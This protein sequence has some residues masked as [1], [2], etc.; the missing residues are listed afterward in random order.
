MLGS[1]SRGNPEEAEQS[2][3]V[4]NAQAS[5]MA[6]G[7]L[8]G[9]AKRLVGGGA[10][11]VGHKGRQSPVLAEGVIFVRGRADRH[12]RGEEILP[13]PGIGAVGIDANG[14]IVHHGQCRGHAGELGIEEP[15]HPLV[16][17]H[18][19]TVRGGEARH[20]RRLRMA[21]RGRPVAPPLAI[22]FGEGTKNGKLVE[23]VPLGLAVLL[24]GRVAAKTLPELLQR[25]DLQPEDGI[26]IDHALLI[27][28]AT[29]G[30]EA[31]QVGA[32]CGSPRDLFNAQ[33]QQVA[34]AP[35]A[36]KIGAGL[37]REDREGGLQR[38]DQEQ[39][40]LQRRRRP[41]GQAAE[42]SQVPDAPTPVRPQGVELHGPAPLACAAW[43]TTLPRAHNQLDGCP[44]IER[45]ERMIAQGEIRRECRF[46]LEH[47]AILQRQLGGT[48]ER[49]HL[50]R[51]D[52][53]HRRCRGSALR[54]W[55][56]AHGGQE[57]QACCWRGLMPYAQGVLVAIVNAPYVCAHRVTSYA[58]ARA[59]IFITSIP[60][61]TVGLAVV[62]PVLLPRVGGS[63]AGGCAPSRDGC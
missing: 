47:G 13:D 21:V 6:E 20:G 50:V 12:V 44:A 58:S 14:Q 4:V 18:A 32:E 3:H 11:L 42:V 7:G 27:E 22:V 17:P 26:A 40:G 61:A 60:T 45:A 41:G 19:L 29:G 57:R 8:N 30:G 39:V 52:H 38:I 16:K 63:P 48:P 2:H 56:D 43:L 10:E 5:R 53:L 25:G 15:L 36:G 46:D 23:R 33:V 31:L 55:I 59:Y 35:A 51:P 34:I 49:S 24:E 1:A 37:L 28:R 9:V 62:I 54:R